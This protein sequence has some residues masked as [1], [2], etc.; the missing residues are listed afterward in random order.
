MS[1]TRNCDCLN[2]C[3]DDPAIYDRRKVIPCQQFVVQ[4][5]RES[6]AKRARELVT[7]LGV[8]DQYDGSGL[9]ALLQELKELRLKVK[10]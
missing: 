10:S 2:Q 4:A 9:V 8:V 3:G 5:L 1:E 6:N 7:E